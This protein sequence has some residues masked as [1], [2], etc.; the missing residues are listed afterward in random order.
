MSSRAKVYVPIDGSVFADTG[1]DQLM[2]YAH[3]KVAGA[4][5]F[6]GS[7]QFI[8]ALTVAEALYPGYSIS[9]NYISD[10]GATC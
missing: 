9:Q 5:I 10:L 6:V 4:L 3:S 7:A 2:K 1:S 8:V